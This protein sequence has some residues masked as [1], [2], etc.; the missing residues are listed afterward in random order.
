[1]CLDPDLPG[2]YVWGKRAVRY[3]YARIAARLGKAPDSH[4]AVEISAP[5]SE[6]SRVRKQLGIARFSPVTQL[7]SFLGKIPDRRLARHFGV[8][9]ATV[10][11][12]RKRLGIPA[13]NLKAANAEDRLR[14]YLDALNEQLGS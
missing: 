5:A 1:M 4:L 8:A 10:S 2:A 13:A 12:E 6:V 9:P 14:S 3:N 11:K 7:C